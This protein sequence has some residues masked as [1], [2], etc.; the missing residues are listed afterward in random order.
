[1]E[2][3]P[4]TALDGSSGSAFLEE[5]ATVWLEAWNSHDT[6]RVLELMHPDIEW[7]D[8]IFWTHVIYGREELRAY[9]DKIWEVMPDVRFD[10]VERFFAPDKDAGMVLFRQRGSAPPKLGIDGRFDTYGCDIFLEFR[11]GLLSKYLAQYDLGGMMRQMGALPERQ[12][13][14]GGAYYLSLMNGTL[15]TG[16]PGGGRAERARQ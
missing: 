1:M 5:F 6:E 3:R 2:Q 14:I 10:E 15:G 7:D 4:Q 11:D 8:R 16:A 12:G 9:V 13:R